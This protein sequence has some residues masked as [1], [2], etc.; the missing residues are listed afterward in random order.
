ME[1]KQNENGERE[2]EHERARVNKKNKKNTE[3][4]CMYNTIS[5]VKTQNEVFF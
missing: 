1:T 4:L 2:Q 5:C 3:Q